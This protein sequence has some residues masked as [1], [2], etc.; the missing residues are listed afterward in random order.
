MVIVTY[1]SICS[2]PII[3]LTN[4]SSVCRLSSPFLLIVKH[5]KT[6]ARKTRVIS[7]H[8]HS[9]TIRFI[10]RTHNQNR[11]ARIPVS[12]KST[13]KL[14]EEDQRIIN[15]FKNHSQQSYL[16]Y[17]M[18]VLL[19]S[20]VSVDTQFDIEFIQVRF[21]SL[22]LT[23]VFYFSIVLPD[24]EIAR[25]RFSRRDKQSTGRFSPTTQCT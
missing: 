3:Q 25:L 23:F 21:A 17:T 1:I 4:Q 24:E 19:P 16:T 7:G 5:E 18:T 15:L 11:I 6:F 9:R 20:Y 22:F 8:I 14:G 2:A 13:R 12:Q 10:S